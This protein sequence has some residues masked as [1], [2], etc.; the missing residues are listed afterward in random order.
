MRVT[1]YVGVCITLMPIC[2]IA[3]PHSGKSHARRVAKAPCVFLTM[4]AQALELLQKRGVKSF[5]QQVLIAAAP[6]FS[7]F[8]CPEAIP[9]VEAIGQ[10]LQAWDPECR[11]V[12]FLI[13][14]VHDL[15]H[16]ATRNETYREIFTQLYLGFENLA[17]A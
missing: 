5:V 9:Q 7:P 1:T 14:V 12:S 10:A 13:F 2:T 8:S 4:P 11:R 17:A 6:A 3:L 15:P 16:Q